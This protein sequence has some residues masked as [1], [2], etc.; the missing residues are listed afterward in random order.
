MVLIEPTES[1]RAAQPGDYWFHT[2]RR[3][4]EALAVRPETKVFITDYIKK[5][6]R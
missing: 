2:D 3:M 6:N 1:E 5:P 4:R